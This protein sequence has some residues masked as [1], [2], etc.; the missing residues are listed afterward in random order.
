MKSLTLSLLL[1]VVLSSL[2][3]RGNQSSSDEGDVLWQMRQRL[4]WPEASSGLNIYAMADCSGPS[5]VFTTLVISGPAETRFEQKSGPR[6]VLG[7]HRPDSSWM[8][9]FVGDTTVAIDDPTICFLINHELHAI[10]FYPEKRYGPWVDEKDTLY[11]E[12]EAKML[13]FLDIKGGRVKTFYEKKSWRP[14]GFSIQNHLGRGARQVDMLFE[15]WQVSEGRRVFTEARFLQGQDVYHY[16]FT[17]I[18]FGELPDNA[19]AANTP[20]IRP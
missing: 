9:D 16:Q 11:Y 8:H 17:E 7:V 12:E 18:S 13:T 15:N 4:G 1:L 6:H 2:S 3:C 14:L 5:S 10:A 19:F 20:L